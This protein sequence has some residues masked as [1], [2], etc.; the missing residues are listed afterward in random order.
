MLL[1]DSLPPGA[2]AWMFLCDADGQVIR[3]FVE[4]PADASSSARSLV[5]R[6]E[7]AAWIDF[8]ESARTRGTFLARELKARLD[9]TDI[10][11]FCGGCPSG[12]GVLVFAAVM[13]VPSSSSSGDFA[14]PISKA[15]HDLNNPISSIISSCDYLT[16]Y[17]QENLSPEQ[18]EMIGV[19]ESAARTLLRLS[20][21]IAELSTLL[22]HSR[23]AVTQVRS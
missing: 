17:A 11:L 1:G 12:V 22:I 15:I 10:R 13:G 5:A 23:P 9:D 21:R 18:M 3:D 19:I 6:I 4:D 7:P 20:A 2:N 14:S 8:L 16:E